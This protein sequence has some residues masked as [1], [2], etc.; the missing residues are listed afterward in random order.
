LKAAAPGWV[1]VLALN[2]LFMPLIHDV[3]TCDTKKPPD[4]HLVLAGKLPTGSLI[5]RAQR[6]KSVACGQY[7][8]F[9]LM[10]QSHQ[11]ALLLPHA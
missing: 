7:L 4:E 6:H 10:Q 11:L 2:A 5:A 9:F 1:S 8:H 3:K